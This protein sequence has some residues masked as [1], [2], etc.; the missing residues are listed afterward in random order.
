MKGSGVQGFKGSRV[1]PAPIVSRQA[2]PLEPLNPRTFEPSSRTLEPPNPRTLEPWL[3]YGAAALSGATIAS[4]FLW[5]TCEFLFPNLFP[6]RMAHC[7]L[8][9]P[10][11]M[12]IGDLTGPFGLSF[13]MLWVSAAVV[14]VICRPRHF[15]PL[16]A[17]GAATV[18]IVV[19]GAARLS[20]IEAAM[21]GAPTTR[22]SLIQGNVGI[23]EKGDISFFD[24]N[25]EKYQQLSEDV[26]NNVDVIV[27]PETVSQ[28]WVSADARQLE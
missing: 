12:Q 16:L 24:I 4:C 9:A 17:A 23:K 6:W 19:Y 11:L 28:R 13:V 22:F 7:Q 26:Q 20:M 8:H 18:A 10:V 14:E 5:V 2:L 25:L 1:S 15:T 3:A 27:W 21:H